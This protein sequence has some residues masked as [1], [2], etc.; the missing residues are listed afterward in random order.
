VTSEH[1]EK[2]RPIPGTAG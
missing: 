2:T 1:H